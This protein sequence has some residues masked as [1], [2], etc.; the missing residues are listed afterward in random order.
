MTT[1]QRH[2]LFMDCHTFSRRRSVTVYDYK[3]N[4]TM[5]GWYNKCIW[6]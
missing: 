6:W 4:I 1:F 5:H 2:A 3:D